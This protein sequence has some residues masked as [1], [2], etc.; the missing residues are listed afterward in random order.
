MSDNDDILSR[1]LQKQAEDNNR[2]EEDMDGLEA[3]MELG[4]LSNQAIAER[5]FDLW[6]RLAKNDPHEA[7][8]LEA[9]RRL[10]TTRCES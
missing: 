6:L 7:L 9:S 3:V 4:Q 10:L 8:I 2:D 1:A 5:L